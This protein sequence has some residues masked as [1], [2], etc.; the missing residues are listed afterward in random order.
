MPYVPEPEDT[1]LLKT[2]LKLYR[3]FDQFA[4]AIMLA[5]RLNDKALYTEIF[6]GVEDRYANA[7]L[8]SKH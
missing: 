5:I 7:M 1:D 6:E 2:A 3:K 4:N 8:P